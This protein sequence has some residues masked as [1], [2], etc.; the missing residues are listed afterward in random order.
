MSQNSADYFCAD[1]RYSAGA[2]FCACCFLFFDLVGDD[3]CLPQM[4][5]IISALIRVTL[6]EHFCVC[7][8]LFFDLVWD[9]FCLPQMSQNFADY[10]CADPRYSAGAFLR[11]LLFIF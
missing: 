4:S 8:F 2:F 3:F 1:P 9:D 6:R 7:C 11:V 10:F 5:Q